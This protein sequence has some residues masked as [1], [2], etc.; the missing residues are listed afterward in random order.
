[1][2]IFKKAFPLDP[3]GLLR[4]FTPQ[5]AASRLLNSLLRRQPAVL[6]L[7]AHHA[8]QSFELKA[9]PINA[10]LTI[11]HD[12]ELSPADPS[13]LPDVM[14]SIDTDALL[15]RGWRP[16]QPLPR[17]SGYV[18]ITGDAALAQ[19]LSKLAEAWRPDIEDLLA[20]YIGD[21]PARQV[22]TGA[23]RLHHLAWRGVSRAS[24][25]LAEY[26]VY[27]AALLASPALIQEHGERQAQLVA[28]LDSLEKRLARIEKR[29]AAHPG[30][31][32]RSES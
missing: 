31:A 21:I 22:V 18:H 19:T 23:A 27:E 30:H 16:G 6:A 29:T 2:V 3:L 25:N 12:G 5:Q 20:Q 15:K 10:R 13:I 7:L 8:G 14:L 32:Q 1:M 24:E 17:E 26:A 28:H 4:A 11:A 9:N